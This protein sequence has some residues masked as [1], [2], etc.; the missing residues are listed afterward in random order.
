[1]NVCSLYGPFSSLGVSEQVNPPEAHGR[2]TVQ[3]LLLTQNF[4]LY[5]PQ[6][7]KSVG[8]VS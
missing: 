4:H 8:M 7:T 3:D 2:E 5:I 6:V 1:M